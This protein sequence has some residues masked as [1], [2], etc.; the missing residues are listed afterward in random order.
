MG[1]PLRPHILLCRGQSASPV[2]GC[3]G[4]LILDLVAMHT[5]SDNPLPLLHTPES[6]SRNYLY[7]RISTVLLIV[8]HTSPSTDSSGSSVACFSLPIATNS[9]RAGRFLVITFTGSGVGPWIFLY[10]YCLSR[11]CS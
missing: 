8:L 1:L 9:Y 7:R 5:W 6:P 4:P 10:M 2:G 3:T 11:P